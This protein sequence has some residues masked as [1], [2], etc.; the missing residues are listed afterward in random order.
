MEIY[1]WFIF[2]KRQILKFKFSEMT[3]ICFLNC[4]LVKKARLIVTKTIHASCY[5]QTNYY[6]LHLK[7]VLRSCDPEPDVRSSLLF[8]L[9]QLSSH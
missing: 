6:N 8:Q 2:R 7:D 1:F 9:T 4:P 3:K 5:F